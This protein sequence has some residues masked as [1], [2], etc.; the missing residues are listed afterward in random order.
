MLT[1]HLLY[2]AFLWAWA[3]SAAGPLGAVNWKHTASRSPIR[4]GQLIGWLLEGA[5]E[6]RARGSEAGCSPL[7]LGR[8]F[9]RSELQIG[10]LAGRGSPSPSTVR[11]SYFIF[12]FKIRL[13]KND[14]ERHACY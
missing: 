9:Q 8:T 4:M 14:W 3:G 1:F 2:E 12:A 10:P 5:P 13:F 11:Y 7:L 6:A